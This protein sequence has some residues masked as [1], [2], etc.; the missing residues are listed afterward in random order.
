MWSETEWRVFSLKVAL[1]VVVA[2]AVFR[3]RLVAGSWSPG[4]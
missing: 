4:R 3:V 1:S 2:E